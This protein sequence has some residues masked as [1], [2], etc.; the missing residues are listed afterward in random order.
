MSELMTSSSSLVSGNRN[1]RLKEV[2]TDD[3]VSVPLGL[4]HVTGKPEKSAV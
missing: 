3:D 1:E 2:M 4:G